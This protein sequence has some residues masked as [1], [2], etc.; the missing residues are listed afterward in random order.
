VPSSKYIPLRLR[1]WNLITIRFGIWNLITIRFRIWNPRKP[2]IE[3]HTDSENSEPS[4]TI[5]S[6]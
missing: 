3:A 6:S 4:M 5:F 1:I 2:E